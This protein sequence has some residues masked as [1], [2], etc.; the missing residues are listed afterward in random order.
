MSHQK[1]RKY[2]GAFVLLPHVIIN[3]PA[4]HNLSCRARCVF[5]ELQKRYNG[6]NNGS[7][8]LSVREAADIVKGSKSTAHKVFKELQNNGFIKLVNKGHMGN[9]H[10]STWLLTTQKDDRTGSSRTDDWKKAVPSS[11]EKASSLKS[12][13]G[14]ST[15][16]NSPALPPDGSG[17][18][19]AM[20]LH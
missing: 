14:T 4:W 16:T 7:I 17:G 9:R 3:S 13:L 2:G 15:R 10:A 6:R 5:I 12:Q 18:G 19:T 1:R 11:N 8:S 20:A